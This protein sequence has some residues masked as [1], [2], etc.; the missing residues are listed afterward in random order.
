[1]V[2]FITLYQYLQI[3]CT[4]TDANI[5]AYII[6]IFNKEGRQFPYN[7]IK[8]FL[9]WRDIICRTNNKSHKKNKK[10]NCSINKT[11]KK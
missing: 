9:K 7:L 3:Y 10:D 5:N 11:N 1:V 6:K 8:L 2:L 4:L